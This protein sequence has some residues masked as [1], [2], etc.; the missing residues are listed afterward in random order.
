MIIKKLIRLSFLMLTTTTTAFAATTNF[1]CPQP[2]EIQSTDFTAPSIW[3][4][5][6]VANSAPGV[7][8]IGLGGKEVREFLGAES[9]TV[10]H[11]RG[12]VCIYQ[13][14]GG[15]SVH[16]Y[17]AKIKQIVESNHY[18]RKHFAKVSEA[19]DQAE[20]Y[21]NKYPMDTAVGFIGY[22]EK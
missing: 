19:F 17:E 5:P 4:A 20:P 6:P 16:E 9:T 8:G 22:Q 7:I 10:N 21:L 12:W 3:T 1:K 14:Q 13:S 15:V 18:L 11:R 2:V